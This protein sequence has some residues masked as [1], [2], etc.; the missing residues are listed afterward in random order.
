[1]AVWKK[2]LLEFQWLLAHPSDSEFT[3]VKSMINPSRSIIL[4]N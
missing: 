2:L 4:K 3:V 1:M